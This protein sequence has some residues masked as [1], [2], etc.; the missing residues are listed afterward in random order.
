MGNINLAQYNPQH[1]PYPWRT[2]LSPLLLLKRFMPRTR[3]ASCG[4]FHC[5]TTPSLPHNR[6]E[7]VSEQ[8]PTKPRCFGHRK[9]PSVLPGSL[10]CV[11]VRTPDPGG[12]ASPGRDDRSS[13]T[14][15]PL[16]RAAGSGAK[17]RALFMGCSR[18]RKTVITTR[19][20]G[21]SQR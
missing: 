10:V 2:S 15:L 12:H 19:G 20:W 6:L 3:W 14:S 11:C 8:E 7:Q 5:F 18:G 17:P 9:Q 21:I 13:V 4:A 1:Y 16:Q